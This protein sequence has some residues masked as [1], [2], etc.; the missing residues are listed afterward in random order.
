MTLDLAALPST[1]MPFEALTG[2]TKRGQFAEL[3]SAVTVASSPASVPLPTLMP[4]RMRTSRPEPKVRR[5]LFL[6]TAVASVET[7]QSLHDGVAPF[8]VTFDCTVSVALDSS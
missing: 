7:R 1:F 5:A 8:H 3:A 6:I 2:A 4:S